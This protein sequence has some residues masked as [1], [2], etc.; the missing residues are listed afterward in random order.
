MS[1]MAAL[2][3][4]IKTTHPQDNFFECVGETLRLSKQARAFYRAYDKAFDCM[5]QLS[6][7]RLSLKGVAH[8]RD[9][10]KRT[11]IPSCW[12]AT[13]GLQG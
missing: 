3:Q 4:L 5:D 11:G 7:E 12:V 10:R 1:R 8:F 13:R 6:W 2:I 9:H